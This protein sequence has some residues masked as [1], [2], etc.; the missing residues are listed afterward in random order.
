MKTDE[1]KT[2]LDRN[3]K[4]KLRFILPS[5]ETIPDHFHL[6]EVGRIEKSFIDCG[7]TKRSSVTCQL[8]LWTADDVEHRLDAEKLLRVMNMADPILKSNALPIEVEYGQDV[9]S[10]YTIGNVVSLFGS[11]Q[12]TLLGKQTDCLAKEKCGIEC[13]NDAK[14]CC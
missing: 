14:A 9:A 3:P 1:F 2:L 10:I 11:I 7:G 8:Q 12:I 4:S 13:S 5:G 6:T